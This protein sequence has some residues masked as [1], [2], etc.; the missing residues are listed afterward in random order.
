ME[1]IKLVVL[2]IA[3]CLCVSRS[4]NAVN[5][6]PSYFPGRSGNINVGVTD[7][8]NDMTAIFLDSSKDHFVFEA[9]PKSLPVENIL[10]I[11]T[12]SFGLV[13]PNPTASIPSN[14]ATARPAANVMFAIESFGEGDLS[15][16]RLSHMSAFH[17]SHPSF[18]LEYLS[19]SHDSLSLATSLATGSLPS[20]HGIVASHWKHEGQDI[21]AFSSPSA[22]SYRATL[23]DLLAQTFDR[24]SLRISFSANEAAAFAFSSNPSLSSSLNEHVISIHD[25][26]IHSV[27]SSTPNLFSMSSSQ[28]LRSLTQSGVLSSSI[29]SPLS[30]HVSPSSDSIE[31]MW[32]TA[33][34]SSSSSPSSAA[35]AA[36]VEHKKVLFD[37]NSPAD[38][39]FFAELSFALTLPSSI[40][41]ADELAA[42]VADNIPD[43]Y[44]V[45]FASLTALLKKYGR[46]SLELQT[47]VRLL[48]IIIPESW[49]RF[50]QLYNHHAVCELIF[51]G[52]SSR[53]NH[54]QHQMAVSIV[55]NLLPGSSQYYPNIYLEDE[56]RLSS[57]CSSLLSALQPIGMSVSCAIASKANPANTFVSL[58]SVQASSNST[59]SEIQRYQIT[60]WTAMLLFTILLM[61]VCFIL[62]MQFKKD[63]MLYSTFNPHDDHEHSH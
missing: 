33:A 56:S 14:G 40:L 15:S 60:L 48:D 54:N 13:Q 7:E 39:A 2:L 47:A 35:T 37:L 43:S 63:N 12:H 53:I 6:G 50:S 25:H 21:Q 24:K 19:R 28:I 61:S 57:V 22:W 4:A 17:S 62:N 41:Q 52:S 29:E 30:V 31:V 36:S 55:D 51:L 5:T 49:R 44:V 46:D 8:A 11:V 18:H 9:A 16:Q 38:F 23:S 1:S 3:S 20:S 10:D 34:S 42:Q 27:S 32:I 26:S 58:S 45:Y 59:Y